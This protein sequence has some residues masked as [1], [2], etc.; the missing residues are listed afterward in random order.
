MTISALEK[1]QKASKKDI[2]LLKMEIE[3][4]CADRISLMNVVG[5]INF[6]TFKPKKLSYDYIASIYM[7]ICLYVYMFICLYVYI[8]LIS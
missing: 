1:K 3:E 7:F 2:K 6:K 8:Y 4:K 5:L